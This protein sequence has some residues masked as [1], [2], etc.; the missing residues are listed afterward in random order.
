MN[1]Y[2]TGLNHKQASLEIREKFALTKEKK[3]SVLESY[4]DINGVTGCVVLSTCNRT[5][6]YI[7]AKNI[8]NIKLPKILCSIL[9]ISYEEFSS[10]FFEKSE[11]EA[12]SHL[13]L[14]S[15]GIH[16]QILGDD[17]I[18]T[19]VRESIEYSRIN[20]FSDNYLETVFNTA[21]RAAKIIKTNIIIRDV[22]NSSA[23]HKAVE[24][25]KT[26]CSLKDKEVVVIGNGQMGRMV[27]ELLIKE[28]AIVTI[29]RRE[30][31]K[32]VIQIPKGANSIN[33][34]NRY[35]KIEES[36]I[37]LSATTSPHYTLHYEDC[38]KLKSMPKIMI[39]LAVP[40]DIEPSI[41]NITGTS[42]FTIDDLV[43]GETFLSE[44]KMLLAESII[45]EQV[46]KYYKWC[47]YKELSM[48]KSH[49]FIKECDI[50][51]K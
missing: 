3:I 40:R 39:D 49:R 50:V 5:E 15:S 34:S 26:I 10:Y 21:I 17:Q 45:N 8:D 33:Y 20:G 42:I 27:S 51:R 32:G 30:Y 13:C 46:E 38:A 28:K 6:I 41:E 16:S 9:S 47:K 25:L 7:S 2:M 37:V 11:T 31:K 44:D 14:V 23:P 24:K 22:K 36:Y 19:Q 29:T 43:T 1:I 18:I 48:S 35:E 4:K 12:I